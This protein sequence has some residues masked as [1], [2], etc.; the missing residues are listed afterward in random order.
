[1]PDARQ[2]L[3][4]EQRGEGHIADE[5]WTPLFARFF[6]FGVMSGKAGFILV[7]LYRNWSG[8]KNSIFGFPVRA[9][10][11]WPPNPLNAVKTLAVSSDLLKFPRF[12][13][14]NVYVV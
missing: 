5:K 14:L 7:Q 11:V 1:M 2:A 9:S 4:G 12:I 3:D 13:I 10:T 6:R 8:K